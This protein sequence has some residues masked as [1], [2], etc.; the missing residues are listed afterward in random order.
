MWL[1]ETFK[2]PLSHASALKHGQFNNVIGSYYFLERVT[3]CLAT[4]YQLKG[5]KKP[6]LRNTVIITK[7]PIKLSQKTKKNSFLHFLKDNQYETID[8]RLTNSVDH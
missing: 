8:R 6:Q 1:R 5:W 7:N 4:I 2:T 3:S